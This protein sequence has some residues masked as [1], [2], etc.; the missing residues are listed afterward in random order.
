M[1]KLGWVSVLFFSS[2][3]A[4]ATPNFDVITVEVGTVDNWQEL[5][6]SLEAIN[7]GTVSAQTSGRIVG[8]H[9]DVN[10]YVPKGE[11]ILEITSKEQS[12]RLR[13]AKAQ[14]AQAKAQNTEAQL[15]LKR[16]RDLFPKGAISKGQLDNAIASAKSTS[17]AVKAS[18]AQIDEA[19]EA[20][21]YT[22]VRAPYAGIVTA[23]Y[24]ELGETV[25]AGTQLYSGVSLDKMRVVIEVPQRYLKSINKETQFVIHTNDGQDIV[26]N[27]FTLF[28]YADKQTHSFKVRI[29]LPE[30]NDGSLLPGM[31]VKASF[32][33][34]QREALF[35]PKEA[36]IRQS[37]L[38]AVYIKMND[39]FLL[40]QV[41][42][43]R[44]V[45]SQYEILAGLRHGE[46]IAADA[47][48][49]LATMGNK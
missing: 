13:A 40:R 31:W 18:Q 29:Y 27:D 44:L 25:A 33:I 12:A 36:V 22:L 1:I 42:L 48:K 14:L 16:Y 28:S 32:I 20:L 24:V 10:D 45:G 5:D 15:Q 30:L 49:V 4:L 9:Y 17:S 46:Q 39:K 35:V 6:G 8:L 47:Y 41:R 3:V 38:S 19:K 26:S 43:G 21:G 2:F 37:E 7:R 34:G 11:I 23:R